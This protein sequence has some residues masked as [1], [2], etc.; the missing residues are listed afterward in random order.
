MNMKPSQVASW[1]PVIREV[2]GLAQ[3]IAERI[4]ARRARRRARG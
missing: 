1:V 2:I 3:L 4:R